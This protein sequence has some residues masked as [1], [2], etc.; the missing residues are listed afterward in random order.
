MN[1]GALADLVHIIADPNLCQLLVFFFMNVLLE[2]HSQIVS[3]IFSDSVVVNEP[4]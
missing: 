2:E 4:L 3:K 1:V